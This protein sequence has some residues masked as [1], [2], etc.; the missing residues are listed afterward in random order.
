MSASA[1]LTLQ[2]VGLGQL[3]W[4]IR[5]A[6]VVADAGTGQIVLWNPAAE[7]LFGYSQTEALALPLDH[8][9]PDRLKAAHRAGLASYHATG[10]GA[11]IDAHMPVEVPALRKT[12]EEV[13]VELMLTPIDHAAAPGHFVLAIIR[14]VSAR[15]RAEH[16]RAQLVEEHAARLAAE[17]AVRTRDA[18]ILAA[19]HEL[20][21]PLTSLKGFIQMLLYLLEREGALDPV[22]SLK[23]LRTIDRQADNLADL[24]T[25]LLTVSRIQTGKLLLDRAMIDLAPLVR[26]TILAAQIRTDHHTLT[27]DAPLP[28][29]AWSD[30]LRVEQVLT[31]LLDNA[32]KFSPR[33]G[34]IDVAV[35]QASPEMAQVAVRDHGLGIPPEQRAHIFERFY[36]AHAQSHLSGLGLGLFISHEIVTLHGGRLSVEFP[37]DGGTLFVVSLPTSEGASL[38][39]VSSEEKTPRTETTSTEDP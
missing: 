13:V 16:E 2:D 20:R 11:L 25:Q 38:T 29:F 21:T 7:E 4:S 17:E 36:Q 15:K 24:I 32:I 27:L 8:L 35:W 22:R 1:R 5:D 10:Q 26:D 14:D 37:F 12:G 33:G 31:N 39:A 28:V 6:V 30:A 19:S 23:T 9:V 3:F 18:F 34:A